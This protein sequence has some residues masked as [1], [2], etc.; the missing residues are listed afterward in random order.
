MK[1]STCLLSVCLLAALP[2]G[3]ELFTASD[4]A[5]T[6]DMPS[7]WK[8]VKN[9][10][11]HSVLSLEKKDERI[12]IK[13]I[14]CTTQTCL[15]NQINRDV[16][17]VK[18]KKMTLITNTY[19]GEEIKRFE[20]STGDPLYYINFYTPQ[21]DFS[22]GY[23]LINGQ[24]YSILAKNMTY[25]ETDLVFSFISP[26]SKP[27]AAAALPGTPEIEEADL[28]PGYTT[29]AVPD[30]EVESLEEFPLSQAQAQEPPVP[31]PITPP[32]V[33]NP[34][35]RVRGKVK[36]FLANNPVHTLVTPNM[37]PYIRQLG[38][39][40]DVLMGLILL[41]FI[42]W[43]G[44]GIV[45]FFI[46]PKRMD[47]TA[48][49]NSLYPIKLERRYGT[50][51]L[52]LRAK[53]N[54]GNVLTALSVRW[55]ALFMF[56]GIV[57]MLLALLALAATSVSQQLHLLPLSAFVYSTLYSAGSLVF[58]LGF[59]IFFCGIV[60][61]QLA[62]NE[63]TLY[64]NRGRK[65]AVLLQKGYSLT[66]E[67]Y[68]IYFARSKELLLARRKRFSLRRQ[69]KLLSK[70]QVEFATITE[71]S[72]GRAV[73]RMLCGHLWGML[74][75]DYDIT[76]AMDSRGVIENT[77]G[78]FNRSVCNI[79][80]PEAVAARDMLAVSLLISIRD[81]DKWYPWFN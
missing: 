36:T 61:G 60:W 58:P 68:Q 39:G 51:S 13:K 45:R 16:T 24:G 42:G 70:D 14:T 76:G 69:W 23:F 1:I 21:N 35:Q 80:K 41:F 7:G 73:V 65:A 34:F 33:P 6:L 5:F 31:Q 72:A 18:S 17:E 26:L 40:Y 74:R 11:Q 64:D 15:E 62:M 78:L 55:D 50:P 71:R 19:T 48:N 54:Q 56:F 75:A 10:P 28:L 38:R 32:A 22:A 2:A 67:R 59:V 30:V 4:Q 47:L 8:R 3:A 81:R 25:A 79:D 20:F 63:I 44:A 37:P 77:H 66:Q 46:R 53:D 43:C 27:A 49:P 52:I 29:Q 57:M 9:P 12:D